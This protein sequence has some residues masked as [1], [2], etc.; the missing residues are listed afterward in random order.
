MVMP[1]IPT[2]GSP[3]WIWPL[4]S[5][6]RSKKAAERALIGFETIVTP[7]STLC[8]WR[9]QRPT[10][11]PLEKG[12]LVVLDHGA[13][14]RGYCSDMTR[15]V[16]LGKAPRQVRTLYGAVLAAQEAAKRTIRPGVKAGDV[17]LAARDVLK[18]IEAWPAISRT[19]PDTAPG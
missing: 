8:V 12:E 1:L 9:M 4:K 18:E 17:D 3:S 14:I 10:S 19:A 16:F 2:S 15:T 6:T 5:N 11:K 7:P 13:I